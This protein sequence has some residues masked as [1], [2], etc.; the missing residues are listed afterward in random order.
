MSQCAERSRGKN[1]GATNRRDGDS[2]KIE[3]F[4][5]TRLIFYFCFTLGYI[6]HLYIGMYNICCTR[7]GR[8]K[9]VIVVVGFLAEKTLERFTTHLATVIQFWKLCIYTVV[10]LREC[11]K[12]R[13]K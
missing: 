9:R 13:D 8:R 1:A 11:S 4:E 6:I 12:K 5:R 2:G 3:K 10:Y 7:P